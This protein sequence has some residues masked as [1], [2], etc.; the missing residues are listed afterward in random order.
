MR[1][2]P[3]GPLVEV[4]CEN[5]H[6]IFQEIWKECNEYFGKSEKLKTHQPLAFDDC[7]QHNAVYGTPGKGRWGLFN[8]HCISTPYWFFFQLRSWVR[9]EWAQFNIRYVIISAEASPNASALST[10]WY[11]FRWVPDRLI[12]ALCIRT[13]LSESVASIGCSD[14]AWC[15][16]GMSICELT[17]RDSV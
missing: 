10:S 17:L 8:T 15:L 7:R 3:L 11:Q 4:K 9:L 2:H 14:F 1:A 12:T 5:M 16:V 13:E 6:W